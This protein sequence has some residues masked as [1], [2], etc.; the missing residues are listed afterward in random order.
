MTARGGAAALCAVVATALLLWLAGA[1]SDDAVRREARRAQLRAV[2][3]VLADVAYTNVPSDDVI[4]VR[5]S[6]HLG[7]DAPRRV[8]RAFSDRRPAALAIETVAPGGYSGPIALL[9]GIRIDG[10]VSAVRV[11]DHR[12]TRGLGD[13]I[14][15]EHSD[16][17]VSFRGRR[18]GDPPSEQWR[19]RRDGGAFDQL[20]GATV[21]PR[22]VVEAVHDA[23]IYFEAHRTDLFA[24]DDTQP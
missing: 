5:D 23:L 17:I 10:S 9:V 1:L 3:D 24:V 4:V 6:E 22:A 18:I 11:I 12:E 8:Y 13:R 2:S 15:L 7:G 16:W 20:T 19:V 14:E 21:T